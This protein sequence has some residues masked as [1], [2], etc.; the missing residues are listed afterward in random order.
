MPELPDITVY[1]EAL[2]HRIL[3]RPMVGVRLGSPFVLR[4]VEPQLAAFA[5]QDRAQAVPPRQTDRD[6]VRGG[7]VHRHPPHDRGTAPWR[8]AERRS[9]EQDRT[10]RLRLCERHAELT[11]VAS[12]KN[13]PRSMSCAGRRRSPTSI[14]AASTCCGDPPAFRGPPTSSEPHAQAGAHRSALFS[15]IG[16]AYSDEI[17]HR[18]QLSPFKLTSLADQEERLLAATRATLAEWAERLRQQAGEGFR[19]R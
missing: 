5:R 9:A 11:E 17:L 6:G 2:E 15:G 7:S 1:I 10:R 16:N 14:P 12:P 4:S 3:G 19:R 13:A 18:A 8:A